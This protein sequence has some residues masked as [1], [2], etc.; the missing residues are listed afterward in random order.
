MQW[1]DEGLVLGTRHHGETSV[2]A[3]VL[4]RAHG[5]S[6]GLVRGGRSRRLRPV[7]QPGNIVQLTWR[8]RL[9][10]HLG[11]YQVEPLESLA[12]FLLENRLRLSGLATLTALAQMLPEREPHPRLFEAARIILDAMEDDSVWPALLVR[13]EMGLL[14]ELGFGLDLSQCAATGVTEELIYVSP[15][16]G[17]AVCRAAGLPYAQRLFALPAFLQGEAGLTRADISDGLKL[18][19]FFLERHVLGP[20]QVQMPQQRQWLETQMAV[21]A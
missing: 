13:W 6:L 11:N 3:D 15:K 7:L 4:T 10:D 12:G 9:E 18:T 2:I 14:D 21:A 5:R 8:A 17:K 20:R 16:S 1:M 19:G